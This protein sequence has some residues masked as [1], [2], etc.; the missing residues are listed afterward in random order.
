[1]Y[2]AFLDASKA[3]DKVLHNGLFKK[4]LDKHVPLSLVLLLKNWYGCLCQSVKWNNTIGECLQTLCGV[5]QGGIL[6]PYLFT[7]YV[8][9]LIK[10]LRS[11]G[12]GLHIGSLFVG[13]IFYADDIVLLSPSVLVSK[14]F[15]TF[16]N[17]LHLTGT[18]NSILTKSQLIMFGDKTQYYSSK[19]YLNSSLLQWVEKVKY[20]GTNIV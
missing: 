14:N 19:L 7:L 1:V 11:L 15:L 12:Y 5:R 6:S 8:D 10:K 18:L 4:L 13:C 3:F 9:D 16:V 17:N 20:L 2:G